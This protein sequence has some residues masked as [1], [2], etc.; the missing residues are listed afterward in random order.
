[1]HELSH[2]THPNH[3]NDLSN[4]GLMHAMDYITTDFGAESSS[5]FPFRAW[6]NTDIHRDKVTDATEC[7][8]K[9]KIGQRARNSLQLASLQWELMC[10]I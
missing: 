8:K 6:T 9:V 10:Q 4:S 5:C 1:M 2:D 3:N 7:P